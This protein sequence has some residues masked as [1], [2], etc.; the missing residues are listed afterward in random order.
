MS[1]QSDSSLSDNESSAFSPLPTKN[2]RKKRSNR[3]DSEHSVSSDESNLSEK[4]S[5]LQKQVKNLMTKQKT[6]SKLREFAKQFS[7][8]IREVAQAD[9]D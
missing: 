9:A 3:S 2:K 7:K 6:Q 1:V 4:V 8:Y 5:K